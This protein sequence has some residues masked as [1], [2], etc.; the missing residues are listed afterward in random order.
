MLKCEKCIHKK[1]CIDEANYKDAEACRNFINENDV[2]PVKHGHW[3]VGY[4]HDRV[5]SCCTIQVTT[6]EIIHINSVLTAGQRWTE[7][8]IRENRR[9]LTTSRRPEI[10]SRGA[11]YR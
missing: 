2:A 1:I 3:N 5:C 8:K 4:F 7:V 9:N 10:R 6:L 11:L